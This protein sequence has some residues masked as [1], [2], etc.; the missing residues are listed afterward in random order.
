MMFMLIIFFVL[1]TSFVQGRLDVELPDGRSPASEIK[2]S[3]IVTVK[4]GGRLF[5]GGRPVNRADIPALAKES[6][7]KKI[8]IAGD[9]DVPYG[10]MAN[11]LAV[12]RENGIP[13]AG[14]ML[15]GEQK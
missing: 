1:T 15:S 10:D 4:T 13:E 7:V 11:L 3:L 9:K 12:L 8:L 2:N 5:W 14:L 6:T